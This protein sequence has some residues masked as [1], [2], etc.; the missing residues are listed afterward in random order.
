VARGILPALTR[1]L[2]LKIAS[3]V[4]ALL[5]WVSVR[6]ERQDRRDLP[7]VPI[8]VV[9]QSEDWALEGNPLPATVTVRFS[10]PARELFQLA[11][12]RP[13]LVIPIDELSSGD[14][15]VVLSR[16][17]V[18]FGSRVGVVVE[19]IQPS[20]VRLAFQRV[21]SATVP[22]LPSVAEEL[23]GGWALEMNT[24]VEPRSVRVI[25]PEAELRGIREVGLAPFTLRAGE[26][27]QTLRVAV[28]TSGIGGGRISPDSVT[29]R[30]VLAPAVDRTLEGMVIL[31]APLPPGEGEGGA[32]WEL[33]F[34][35][36]DASVILSGTE[37]RLDQ[38]DVGA[39]RLL[40]DSPPLLELAPGAEIELP[41]RV[42]GV[43][44][45][46]RVRTIPETVRVRRRGPGEETPGVEGQ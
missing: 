18:R 9:L 46:V 32:L 14:T 26:G 43:P 27:E 31:P 1:N 30:V 44:E 25:G 40:V 19:D 28:D 11:L 4:L 37:A 12:D 6:A 23:P 21:S 33:T 41:I 10:G 3:F 13:T 42:E 36:S 45:L 22:V 17:W 34:T 15:A 20:S 29:A 16:D 8:R 35:P 5:L 7:G 24:I 39:L 38:V 2:P